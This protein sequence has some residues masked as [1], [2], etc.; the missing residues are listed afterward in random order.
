MSE[1]RTICAPFLSAS[2]MAESQ[3]FDRHFTTVFR[4]V[5]AGKLPVPDL[6]VGGRELWAE[7]TIREWAADRKLILNEDALEAVRASQLP[8]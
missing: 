6:V 7:T 8:Q 4:W 5:K 3:L 2:M 1:D